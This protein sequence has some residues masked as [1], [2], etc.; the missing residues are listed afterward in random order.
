MLVI[1]SLLYVKAMLQGNVSNYRSFKVTAVYVRTI[2]VGS[3][4]VLNLVIS[5]F[6]KKKANLMIMLVFISNTAHDSILMNITL[7]QGTHRTRTLIS[8][9]SITIKWEIII[10]TRLKSASHSDETFPNYFSVE[11]HWR[12]LTGLRQRNLLYFSGYRRYYSV[13][14]TVLPP[15]RW[16]NFLR[17]RILWY[18]PLTEAT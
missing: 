2:L 9:F 6:K 1:H 10:I 16:I 15:A 13:W 8:L 14:Q 5:K 12:G 18:L 4:P 17:N 3:W 7:F 11:L